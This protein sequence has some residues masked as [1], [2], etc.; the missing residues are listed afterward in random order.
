[1]GKWMA[2]LVR[3]RF[4]SFDTGTARMHTRALMIQGGLV[5]IN[6][7]VVDAFF[8]WIFTLIL[9]LN[10]DGNIR[11]FIRVTNVSRFH[12]FYIKIKVDCSA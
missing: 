8:T 2:V 11:L 5:D 3:G 7:D 10:Y 1:M 6:I 12:V 4:H 9:A